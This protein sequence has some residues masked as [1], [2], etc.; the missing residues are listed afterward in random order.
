MLVI[1]GGR[2][3]R[4]ASEDTALVDFVAATA[5]RAGRVASVCSGA[6]LLAAAGVLDGRRAT[7]HWQECERLA[8]QHPTVSVEPDRIFVRDGNLYTSAGVTAG[9]DL[10]LAL[11]AEDHGRGLALEVARQLVVFLQRP[12]GQ[13]QFSTQLSTQAED[14]ESLSELRA[15]IEDHVGD[16][17]S[18]PALA[19]RAKMSP[20]TFARHFMA[21]L[22]ITPARYVAA[23]RLDAARRRLEESTHGLDRIAADCGIGTSESL[24]RLFAATLGTTPSEY[25]ERFSTA[26]SNGKERLQ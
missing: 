4:A 17:L 25:R 13:S 19:R 22:G 9:I 21:T 14:G 3:T 18:V 20:R 8:S 11:V 10:A 6:F 16:D 7:T 1:S 26:P 5:R 15:W 24:R 2:G 23:V 12:G